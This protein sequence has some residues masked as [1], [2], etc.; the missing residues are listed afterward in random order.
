MPGRTRANGEGSIFPYRNGY[1]AYVWVTKPDGKRTRKY[2]YGKT[3]EIV[4]DKWIK[5]HT[6]AKR[7][8]VAT[9][10]PTVGSYAAYWLAE[11]VEPNRAPLTYAT[12]E[13]LARLYVVPGLGTKRLDRLSVRDVQ[14]WINQV[15]KTCQCC[16]QSKDAHR[17][18]KKQRCC[19]IGKCC[20]GLPSVRTLKGIRA[21]L[22]SALS[23]AQADELVGK[24]VAGLVKLPAVRRRKGNTWSS[25]EARTFLEAAR[26]ATD[27]L[28]PAYVLVLVL[29]LRKG[30][31]L[32][33]TWDHIDWGGWQL[34]CDG[35]GERF[36]EPCRDRY[37][38]CLLVDK[39]LQRVRG[40]LLHRE[41]KTEE[42]DAPLPLPGICVSVLRHRRLRQEAAATA[43]GERWHNTDMVFTTRYGLPVEPRN[44]SRSWDA[45]CL[46]AGVK[47]ITVHD[48]R[49]TCAS[50]LVDLDVH[51]RIAMAILRHADFSITMEV[52]SQ[53]S[54]K[55][56]RDA[57]RRLG[58]SLDG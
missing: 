10:V 17:P 55:A 24:N 50:L 2:V 13:T 38:V 29:G 36:C 49:R 3:R 42:S 35:H 57:L 44:F 52:Y 4:H 18:A 27:Y 6:E 54:P 7:G 51:P 53:A 25:E 41:T 20:K 11:V 31:V 48:A 1:A 56:T 8:P 28:Y 45:G 47:K 33:L 15:A 46:R 34:R 12:Y 5:L 30:E 14:T 43:A 32:G 58:E 40:Q 19:A 26:E 39:Q 37:D 23:Q 16:A 21:V 22:R 9:K